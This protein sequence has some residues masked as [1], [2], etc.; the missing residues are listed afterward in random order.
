MTPHPECTGFRALPA[1]AEL[2]D[3]VSMSLRVLAKLE[4]GQGRR[5]RVR[6]LPDQAGGCPDDA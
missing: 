3:H 5:G 4:R 6:L 1:V 2:S